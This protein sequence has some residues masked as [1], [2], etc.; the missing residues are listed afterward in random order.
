MKGMPTTATNF[1]LPA[2]HYIVFGSAW[3]G[4]AGLG[5]CVWGGGVVG[6]Y[7]E[8]PESAIS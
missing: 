8:N 5:V 7:P 4:I 3:L 6:R 1:M 2:S